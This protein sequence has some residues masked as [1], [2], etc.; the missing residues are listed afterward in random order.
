[1]FRRITLSLSLAALA[2]APALA[3]TK[4]T[5][6]SATEAFEVMGKTRPKSEGQS[7][8]WVDHHVA[9]L[10]RGTTTT[11]LDTSAKK[12]Y[13]IDHAKKEY[14]AVALP[15][16]LPALVDAETRG[17][18]DKMRPMMKMTST[19]T[20]TKEK[21]TIGTWPCRKSTVQVISGSGLRLDMELW[22]TT[23]VD[24]NLRTWTELQRT[25]A[26]LQPTGAD[27][28]DPILGV[29]GVPVL[30]ITSMVVEGQTIRSQEELT[31]IERVDA[32]AGNYAPPV[33]YTTVPFK[34]EQ[35]QPLVRP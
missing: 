28:M 21:R 35:A 24:A 22:T 5:L 10:D 26:S 4:L 31:S 33:G 16:D 32:P 8:V 1:M 14:S 29:E 11:L 30:R 19:V 12:L 18:M 6:H 15:V 25:L 34:L 27:W 17:W 2:C 23:A 3:D 7:V 9:R 13:F 20:P